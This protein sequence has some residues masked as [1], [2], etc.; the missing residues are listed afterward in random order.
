MKHLLVALLVSVVQLLGIG[1]ALADDG[2]ISLTATYRER[3][4][5]P[6]DAVI[7]FELLDVSRAD[8][9]SVRLSSQMFRID[10]V[11]FTAALHF[12]TAM[13]DER[14]SYSVNARILSDGRVMFRTTSSY[15]VITRGAALEAELVLQLMPEDP[16]PSDDAGRISGV[17]WAMIE[18]GGRAF[19]GEDPPTIAFDDDGS[20][21][22]YG[23]CNRFSGT[24]QIASGRIAFPQPI[25][26]T[27]RACEE[28]RMTLEADVLEAFGATAIYAR[29]GPSLAFANPAGIA[30]IRFQERPD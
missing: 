11:P 28:A 29:R 5:L 26:G 21:S 9:P 10:R 1:S 20:F 16:S 25:A 3:I 14:M 12:D 27:L 15:P 17:A 24:A 13:I 8:A 4:A 2:T 19:I 6:A 23:G 22:L 30:V 7:A 18:I